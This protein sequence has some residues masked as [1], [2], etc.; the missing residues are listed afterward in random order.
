MGRGPRPGRYV[1]WRCRIYAAEYSA[2]S[3]SRKRMLRESIAGAYVPHL[4]GVV[5]HSR[6]SK[7]AVVCRSEYTTRGTCKDVTSMVDCHG[8]H[9]ACCKTSILFRPGF[10]V[11]S[12]SK[13]TASLTHMRLSS[14]EDVTAVI[15]R[16]RR[17][18][19][20]C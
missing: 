11:V 5:R 4:E 3:G 10:A 15:D 19:G 8:V 7:I 2:A 16:Q 17:N 20:R 12:G 9:I 1:E 6:Q 13:H 18:V 14:G